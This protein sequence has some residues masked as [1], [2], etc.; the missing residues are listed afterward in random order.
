MQNAV[1]LM[2]VTP[3]HAMWD[4]LEMGKHA[5][6]W[7]AVF[8]STMALTSLLTSLRGQ[9]WSAMTMSMAQSVMTSGMNWRPQSSAD[10]WDSP[11]PTA[12]FLFIMLCLV[13]QVVIPSSWTSCYALAMR[14]HCWT[15]LLVR[16]DLTSVITVK[17][18]E[19]SV[20]QHVKKEVFD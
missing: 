2:A 12:P 9:C 8:S 6:V 11:Q 1:T 5:H 15:A 13:R 18:M 17:M 16:L 4:S 3:A 7:M 10:N 14:P 20:K 19:F